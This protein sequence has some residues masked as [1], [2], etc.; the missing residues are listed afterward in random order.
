MNTLKLI[1]IPGWGFDACVMHDFA[2]NMPWPTQ[3]IDLAALLKKH[4]RL[5]ELALALKKFFLEP[6]YLL[7]WSLG[8]L[9]ARELALR[10][11][12]IKKWVTLASAP[13]FIEKKGVAGIAV[14]DLEALEHSVKT[15]PTLAFRQF[16][17]LQHTNA[18]T[19]KPWLATLSQDSWD[20]ISLMRGLTLLREC[21][22]NERVFKQPALHLAG[23]HD[24]LMKNFKDQLII[25]NA[26]H[27]LFLTHPLPIQEKIYAF[28]TQ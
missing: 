28:I 6:C 14:K 22:F 12:C 8:G 13:C 4:A 27:L 24:P 11:P 23:D 10:Y 20:H 9:I 2:K 25:E 19:L 18:H 21:D 3:I 7:G 15:Q 16:L 5:D 17:K 1:I 26:G